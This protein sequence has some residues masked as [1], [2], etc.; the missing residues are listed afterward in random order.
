VVLVLVLFDNQNAGPYFSFLTTFSPLCIEK[1][2]PLL[3]EH[4][5][6]SAR[7]CCVDLFV[8]LYPEP[9]NSI[10]NKVALFSAGKRVS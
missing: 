2:D 7:R 4:P 3:H 8:F 1:S 10:N 5:D 6:I 9:E